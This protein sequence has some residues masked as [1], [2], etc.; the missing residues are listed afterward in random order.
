[1]TKSKWMLAAAALFFLA[2]APGRAQV[3]IA[4]KAGSLGLGLEL[5]LG[6]SPQLNAR[7]G[8]N[9]FNYTDSHREVS[10]IEY[11]ATAKLRTATALLDW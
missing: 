8:A 3:A 6:I 11:D 7:L 1:M 9:G 2:A 4:G 10:G 5:T